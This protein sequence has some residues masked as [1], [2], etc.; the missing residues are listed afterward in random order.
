MF[1]LL[2][3]AIVAIVVLYLRSDAKPV[4]ATVEPALPVVTLPVI[5]DPWT[6]ESPIVL[7]VVPATDIS[8]V[9]Q[10][11]LTPAKVSFPRLVAVSPLY[12]VI[13]DRMLDKNGKPLRGAALAARYR[14]LA[15]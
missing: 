9:P 10:L 5:A 11:L 15:A 1:D 8:A 6:D 13:D 7:S 14:K 4:P 2:V 12:P 3:Y